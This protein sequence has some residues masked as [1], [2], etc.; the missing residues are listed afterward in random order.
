MVGLEQQQDLGSDPNTTQA[1]S[2]ITPYTEI[3]LAG[4]TYKIS[5]SLRT[6]REVVR[7]AN[8]MKDNFQNLDPEDPDLADQFTDAILDDLQD[9]SENLV[10][11]ML[12]RY[13]SPE[14]IEDLLEIAVPH[15][16]MR[17]IN[18]LSTEE[19][20]VPNFTMEGSEQPTSTPPGTT[21]ML[22]P[23]PTNNEE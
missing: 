11:R 15:E 21:L 8:F 13:H 16:L 9:Q 7:F 23:N 5:V 2:P 12:R 14:E 18:G 20:Y 6:A 17:L 1:R 10:Q 3:S 4:G 19:E 22:S